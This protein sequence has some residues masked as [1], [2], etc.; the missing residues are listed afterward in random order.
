[1]SSLSAPNSGE[2]DKRHARRAD[3]GTE[4]SMISLDASRLRGHHHGAVAEQQRLVDRMG[5]VDHGLA[6]LLPDAAPARPAGWRGSGASSAA[7]GSS[8]SSM[9]GSVTNARAMAPRWR[10]PPGELVRI[11]MAELG[12]A[13]RASARPRPGRA[14]SRAR[15]AARHQPERDIRS[16]RSSTETGRYPGTPW[17]C[18]PPS[19]RHRP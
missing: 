13:R 11:V 16:R 3:A 4:C 19:R 12:E 7:N 5:D 15:H 1:M 8:I 9:P 2:A 10:M 6:G 18:R 17:R 14:I